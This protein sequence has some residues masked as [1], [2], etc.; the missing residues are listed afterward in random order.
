MLKLKIFLK[1]SIA[2][3]DVENSVT[4]FSEGVA[5]AKLLDVQ[6]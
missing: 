2:F 4:P 1:Y 5:F 6:L 3:R